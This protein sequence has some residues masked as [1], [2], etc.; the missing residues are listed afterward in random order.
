ML[1][2]HNSSQFSNIRPEGVKDKPRGKASGC[3]LAL[4]A[5][6]GRRASVY[7]FAH[8]Q[9][10]M[11]PDICGNGEGL[12]AAGENSDAP[13]QLRSTGNLRSRRIPCCLIPFPSLE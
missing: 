4:A 9:A 7:S 11:D 12:G 1:V 2:L 13:L 3:E 6:E 5:V 8:A 10:I